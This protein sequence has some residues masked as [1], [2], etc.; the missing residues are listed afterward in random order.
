MFVSDKYRKVI[1][2]FI[3]TRMIKKGKIE[4]SNIG[5]VIK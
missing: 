5:K 4:T 1:H 2:Y 3:S